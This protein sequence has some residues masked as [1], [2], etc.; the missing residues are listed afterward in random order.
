M[1]KNR[2]DGIARQAKGTIKEATGKITGNEK[3]QAE[4]KAEKIAGRAQEKLG[5]AKDTITKALK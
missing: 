4:G 1:D 3:L 5:K 2:I